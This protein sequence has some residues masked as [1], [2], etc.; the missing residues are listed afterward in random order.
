MGMGVGDQ[1]GLQV[2]TR[3]LSICLMGLATSNN[4]LLLLDDG[5][6]NNLQYINTTVD[7]TPLKQKLQTNTL[8]SGSKKDRNPW[9]TYQSHRQ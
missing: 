8:Y 4:N 1:T 2:N 6:S 9:K 3:S 7:N 5:L